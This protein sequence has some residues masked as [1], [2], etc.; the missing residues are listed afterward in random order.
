VSDS[1]GANAGAVET[2]QECFDPD[3]QVVIEAWSRLPEEVK[4]AMLLIIRNV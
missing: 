2:K 4:A 3:L 1:L